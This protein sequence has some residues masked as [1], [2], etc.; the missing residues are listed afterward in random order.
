MRRAARLT[1]LACIGVAS[2]VL[3]AGASPASAKKLK[4]KVVTRTETF[5]QCVDA[6]SPILDPRAE[7]GPASAVISVGVPGFKGRV[8]DGVITRLSSIGV[9]ITHGFSGDLIIT[10]VSPDGRIFPLALR[11][12]DD[13]DGYGTGAHGCTGSTVLFG[14]G[15]GSAISG[16]VNNGNDPFTGAFRPERPV[17]SLIGGP[18]RG[19]WVLLVYDQEDQETGQL[20][21]FS[22]KFTY[23]YRAVVKIKKRKK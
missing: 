9:R 19:A 21:A 1:L 17:T 22:L 14:D 2:L 23:A 16:F 6:A 12:G 4:K 8:Q 20:D 3:I 13:A 18:A 15:F 11:R 10:L 5:D 7:S